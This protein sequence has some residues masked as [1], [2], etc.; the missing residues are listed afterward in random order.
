MGNSKWVVFEGPDGSGKSTAADK[1][2]RALADASGPTVLQHLTQHSKL[3]EYYVPARTWFSMGLNVVQDRCT[4]SD[5]VYAPVH[6]GCASR[7]GE[8]LVRRQLSALSMRATLIH[9]TASEAALAE[10]I[11][12]RGDDNTAAADLRLLLEGYDREVSWFASLGAKVIT[13]DTTD[14]FPDGSWL[15]EAVLEQ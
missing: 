11:G 1:L 2:V 13:V 10:R 9:M 7:F 5:L 4:M 6:S 14:S 15:L 8:D 3:E 12:V